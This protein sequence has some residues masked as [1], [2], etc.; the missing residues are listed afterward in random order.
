M[1]GTDVMTIY[2]SKNQKL[3]ANIRAHGCLL[4][5]HPF[6]ASPTP[7]NLVQRNRIISGLSLATIVIEAKERSGSLHTARFTKEQERLLFACQW[8]D[9]RKS[10]GTRALL[11]D[12][13]LP[14]DPDGVDDVVN[15]LN[16]CFGKP[17]QD[18]NQEV[19]TK[20]NQ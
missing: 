19:E 1:L 9:D 10:E 15:M 13:A 17:T 11:R 20:Q 14:F 7:R 12:N 18:T 5:E 4:S 2:P 16:F 3:A 8:A 6:P